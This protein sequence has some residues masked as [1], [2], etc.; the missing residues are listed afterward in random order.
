M[1]QSTPSISTISQCIEQENENLES[2]P[3]IK[4]I[5]HSK[6]ANG[7]ETLEPFT[8][9]TSSMDLR[10]ILSSQTLASNRKNSASNPIQPQFLR[11]KQK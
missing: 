8:T 7:K 1:P 4:T 2:L 11:K 9:E 3:L 6:S 5:H 10:I